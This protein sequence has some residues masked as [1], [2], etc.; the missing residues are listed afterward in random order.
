MSVLRFN[1]DNSFVSCACGA[2]TVNTN[3]WH[4]MTEHRRLDIIQQA[5][6]CCEEKSG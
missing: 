6:A 4:G 3:I 2:V 1:R 5:Q